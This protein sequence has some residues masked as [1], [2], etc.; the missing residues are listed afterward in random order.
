MS[1]TIWQD[2]QG[3]A[4]TGVYEKAQASNV[5]SGKDT[6]V[7]ILGIQEGSRYFDFDVDCEEDEILISDCAGTQVRVEDGR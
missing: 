1:S 3:N 4:E 7:T 6:D 2:P 5:Y